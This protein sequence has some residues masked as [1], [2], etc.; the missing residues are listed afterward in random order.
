M[1]KP[2]ENIDLSEFEQF[3]FK[4]CRGDYHPSVVK[5]DIT[6]LRRELNDVRRGM[7]WN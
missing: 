6:R 3:G 4:K 5:N 7:E 1:L 2:K